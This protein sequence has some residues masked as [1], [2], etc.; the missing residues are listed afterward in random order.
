M[1]H[2]N[3]KRAVNI[4]ALVLAAGLLMG[5]F[6]GCPH[7]AKEKSKDLPKPEVAISYTVEHLQQDF[8]GDGYTL[9]ERET[10]NG[11]TGET[12][13][14]A[15]KKYEGFTVQTFAQAEIKADSSTVVQI[16]YDRN[17]IT[18]NLDLASGTTTTKLMDGNKLQGRFGTRVELKGLKKDSNILDK[19]EPELPAIFP[20]S[21]A[22]IY[23]ASWTDKCRITIR[24]DERVAGSGSI[25][26]IPLAGNKKWQ[27]IKSDVANKVILKPEWQGSDYEVY[28]WRL[29]DENGTK[30]TDD[31]QIKSHITV[32]AVINYKNF[33][34]D[35]TGYEIT[36]YSGGQP[37]GKIIIPKNI[38]KIGNS[39]FN[40]CTELTEVKLPANFNS[41]GQQAFSYC[42]K[43]TR[44][45]LSACTSLNSIGESAFN[46]CTELTEVKLPAN[47]NSIGQ[48]A[49]SYCT[50][51][52]RADLSA[53]TSLNSIGNS[54]FN[55]CTELTEV[56]LPA[57]LS[58]IGWSA[59]KNCTKLTRADLSACTSLNSID[60]LAFNNC[61]KLTRADLSA[62]TS[63]NSIGQEVF[64]NCTELTEVKLPAS[65]YSIGQKAFNNCTKLTR[66]DLSACT[67]LN[68]IRQETFNNCTE[69]TEVKLP[70]SLYSIE[71]KAFN[72]CTKLTRADLSA[73]TN[74]YSIG[75]S[76]FNNCTELT[77]VKLPASL[78]SIGKQAFNSCTKLTHA[79]FLSKIG[80]K[81]YENASYTIQVGFVAPPD[82]ADTSKAAKYLRETIDNGGYSDTYWKKN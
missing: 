44:A 81:V 11:K 28:E 51:L 35:A 6:T 9:Y 37:K 41:I 18:L 64:N 24:G 14:A 65:L 38:T 4:T 58:S 75:E 33:I 69:L 43:L 62:C 61:T 12:T 53:C 74:L 70:A 5:L 16:K 60:D 80:W 47:L 49:F 27:N 21:P 66:A 63:L 8:E 1:K 23:T 26:P 20:A 36:G 3:L 67:S 72:S 57:S 54:A 19:W 13:S 56:K 76:A 71:Q 82:L 77:E 46:N 50:K 10:V 79:V 7:K 29:D 30:L 2:T 52:T 73:C 39:A 32:Y 68:S 22:K 42:T 31:Y 15:A 34:Y 78:N 48:Q 55:N 59:F 40:N 17:I 45:D 25:D